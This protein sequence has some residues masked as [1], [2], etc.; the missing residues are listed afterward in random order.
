VCAGVLVS[1]LVLLHTPPGQE[2]Q[3]NPSTVVTMRAAVPGVEN[4]NLVNH[5]KCAIST[6]DGKFLS[7]I[8]TCEQVCSAFRQTEKPP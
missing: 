2:I 6:S 3:I 4:K 8:E 1:S 5:V 7:V